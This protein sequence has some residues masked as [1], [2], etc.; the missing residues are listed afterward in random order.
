MAKHLS[1]WKFKETPITE[2]NQ[3]GKPQVDATCLDLTRKALDVL[4]SSKEAQDIVELIKPRQYGDEYGDRTTARIK[5]EQTQQRHAVAAHL[6]LKPINNRRCKNCKN[7]RNG[8]PFDDCRS[9]GPDV[10]KGACQCCQYSSQAHKCEF[11]ASKKDEES[12]DNA[13]P[14]ITQ[15]MLKKATT[16]QLEQ[17]VRWCK[18]ELNDREG[19]AS[20]PPSAKKRC[21]A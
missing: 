10:F 11:H 6:G 18:A 12:D 21:R 14:T 13:W 1:W 20:F 9:F 16:R 4:R 2:L 7:P 3:E 15:E 19:L 17:T 5:L 8:G